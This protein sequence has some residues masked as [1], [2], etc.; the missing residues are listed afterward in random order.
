MHAAL[1]D[2]LSVSLGLVLA[3]MAARAF[4]QVQRPQQG[5][6]QRQQ[7]PQ[8]RPVT[9][10]GSF[11][12]FAGNFLQVKGKDAA[13]IVSVI[14]QS[15]VNYIGTAEQDFLKSGLYVSLI[16]DIDEDGKLQAD[17][18]ELEIFTPHANTG[19][20][21][22]NPGSDAE[23]KPILKPAAGNYLF[24]GKLLSIKEGEIAVMAGTKKVTGKLAAS[25]SIKVNLND[26]SYA[27]VGDMVKLKGLEMPQPQQRQPQRP[28]P[29]FPQQNPAA[30]GQNNPA[31]VPNAAPAP[32]KPTV[33]EE[34]TIT[35][36]K[37]LAGKKSRK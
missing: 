24:K 26:I 2:V 17:V 5:Q 37:P 35:G 10:E 22:F 23:A 21:V 29:Q 6:Q 7:Q 31:A 32:P 33:A 20:G 9:D 12:G 15:K 16:G 3:T 11:E 1:K 30:A 19:V 8:G 34:L 4:A 25:A 36:S 28:Y 13:Y 14:P 18:A 27:Q